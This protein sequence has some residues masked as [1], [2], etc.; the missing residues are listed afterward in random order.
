MTKREL[1]KYRRMLEAREAELLHLLRNRDGI[2][3]ERSPDALDEDQ[4]ATDRELAIRNLDRDSN[5]LQNVR[6]ALGRIEEGSFG[7]CLNCKKDIVPRRLAAVPSTTFCIVCQELAGRS[8]YEGADHLVEL[9]VSA[10]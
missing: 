10:G 5:V 2:A 7:V 4:Y 8:Q 3:I 6:A 9:L 1:N